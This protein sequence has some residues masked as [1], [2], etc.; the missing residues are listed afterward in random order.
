MDKFNFKTLATK[1][2]K[3][4][5]GLVQS[6]CERKGVTTSKFIHDIVLREI[7]ITVPNNV[8]GK[9]IIA[10]K[11]D[12]DA[13]SWAVKLDSGETIEIISNMSPQYL[14][15]MAAVFGKAIEQRNSVIKKKK[16]DSAAIPSELT[17]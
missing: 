15:D 9:N 6:Y 11:K 4:E 5:A 3:H 17:K 7:N 2:S 1:L 13:F 14:E 8:A 10:Y 16:P 12:A